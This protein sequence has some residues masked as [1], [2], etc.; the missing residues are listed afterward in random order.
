MVYKH[1]GTTIVILF[2]TNFN[3]KCLLQWETVGSV[4]ELRIGAL[5]PTCGC[6]NL[7]NFWLFCFHFEFL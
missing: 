2:I 6:V 7:G 4:I 1:L 3:G 5:G